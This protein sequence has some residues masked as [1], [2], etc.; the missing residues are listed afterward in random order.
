MVFPRNTLRLWQRIPSILREANRQGVIYSDL[1]QHIQDVF[2]ER[3][4]E[5]MTPHYRSARDGNTSTIPSDYLPKDYKAPSFNVK[6]QV[7]D[8]K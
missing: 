6:T 3:G 7:K 2:N 8:D 4:I 1:H 5:I